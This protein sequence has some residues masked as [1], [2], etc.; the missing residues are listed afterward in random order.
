M[1]NANSL[2][3]LRFMRNRIFAK[4]Y[5]YEYIEN[6]VLIIN[7]KIDWFFEFEMFETIHNKKI[8]HCKMS[9][10]NLIDIFILVIDNC[11]QNN[12]T[13]SIDSSQ[14]FETFFQETF[15]IVFVR[16]YYSYEINVKNLNWLWF[17]ITISKL[18]VWNEIV[19]NSTLILIFKLI[20]WFL[21]QWIMQDFFATTFDVNVNKIRRR[22][23]V[24]IIVCC[25]LKFSLYDA[26]LI[27]N[28][29]IIHFVVSFA[30]SIFFCWINMNF[31]KFEYDFVCC[32]DNSRRRNVNDTMYFDWLF[33]NFVKCKFL[34]FFWFWIALHS[35]KIRLL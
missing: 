12:F 26:K 7:N 27:Q 13:K 20:F 22:K 33:V 24:E 5:S 35:C 34:S 17:E 23:F 28:N 2:F 15:E 29:Q 8:L 25:L 3:E 10:S 32:I 14:F 6:F 4:K 19:L 11:I 31:M 16:Q 18:H 21:L 9:K 1:I 30:K